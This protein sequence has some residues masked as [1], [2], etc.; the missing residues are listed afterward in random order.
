MV[1]A[2]S[3]TR[4]GSTHAATAQPVVQLTCDDYRTAPPDKRYSAR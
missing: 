2:I 1:V 3:G 4:G